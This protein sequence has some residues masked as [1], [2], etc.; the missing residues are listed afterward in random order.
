M[1]KTFRRKFGCEFEF[2]THFDEVAKILPQIIRSVYHKPLYYIKKDNYNSINNTKWNLKMDASTECELN[3]PVSHISDLPNIEKVLKKLKAKNLSITQNDGMHIHIQANDIDY[4]KIVSAWIKME[5]IIINCFPKHRR[6]NITYCERLTPLKKNVK[7]SDYYLDSRSKASAHHCCISGS[8]IKMRKT[9]EFRL[10]ESTLDFNIVKNWILF[11]M[12]FLE[13]AKENDAIQN[14][15]E[16][17]YF[18][19]ISEIIYNLNIHNDEVEKFIT[20]RYKQFH[21]K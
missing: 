16:N 5:K 12:Y 6:N 17:T 14:V 1:R 15:C 9:V 13:Y 10:C 2:S 21:G 18:K 11:Y 4:D 7:I 20:N 8:S 3:T 19:N